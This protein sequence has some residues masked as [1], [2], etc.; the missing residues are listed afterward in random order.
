MH[1]ILFIN[2]NRITNIIK[3]KFKKKKKD[4]NYYKEKV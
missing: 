3:K 1:V 4:E 2:I